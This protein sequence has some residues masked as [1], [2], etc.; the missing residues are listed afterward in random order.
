VAALLNSASSG[1]SF[2]LSP[3]EGISAFNSVFPGTKSQYN[4]LK[5]RFAFTRTA[6][7]DML[8]SPL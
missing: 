4:A 2:E 6:L 8:A 5:D 1:V 3:A 7:R